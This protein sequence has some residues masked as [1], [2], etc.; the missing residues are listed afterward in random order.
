[1]TIDS[2]MSSILTK[3]S[4]NMFSACTTSTSTMETQFLRGREG[5]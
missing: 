3:L 4:L 1:M 5:D 2:A